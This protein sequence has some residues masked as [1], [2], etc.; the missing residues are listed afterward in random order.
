MPNS[1]DQQNEK[2]RKAGGVI[3]VENNKINE[4]EKL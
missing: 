3:K 1:L 2:T 4:R